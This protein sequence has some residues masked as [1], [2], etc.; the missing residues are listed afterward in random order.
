M[1]T[2]PLLTITSVRKSIDDADE[3][4]LR[5]LAA[6]FAAVEHL[7]VLKKKEGKTVVDADREEEIKVLWKK[8]AAKLGLREELVLLVLDFILAESRR[9]QS[10]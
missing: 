9:L 7:K 4:L 6:R 8:R 10:L 2:D 3:I 1:P 5:A